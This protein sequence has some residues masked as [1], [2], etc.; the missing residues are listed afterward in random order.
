MRALA[1]VTF[2]GAAL[3]VASWGIAGLMQMP[4]WCSDGYHTNAGHLVTQIHSGGAAEAAG[5]QVGDRI[6]SIGGVP[7][8]DLP[9]RPRR[10]LPSVGESLAIEARR[11]GQ[12]LT[13]EL[14]CAAYPRNFRL[15]RING[16]IVS[17][18]FLA[19]AT[20]VLFVA[21][22][23]PGL[24]FALFGLAYGVSAFEG[25]RIGTLE[26]VAG[27]VEITA[28]LLWL[29][30][31][32]HLL[33]TF[34]KRKAIL[35]RRSTLWLLYAPAV[36]L[37]LFGVLDLLADPR[38]YVHF[39]VATAGLVAIYILLVITALVHSWVRSTGE[40]RK[41]SGF[42]L[43]LLALAIA[44][45]PQLARGF[46]AIAGLGEGLPGSAYY[47]LSAAVIPLAMATAIARRRGQ[48]V[49][50]QPEE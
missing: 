21:P 15:A 2:T 46:A 12:P 39:A 45:M 20:W 34:P 23:P 1:R 28:G 29:V 36:L 5:L 26:G 14:V 47:S 10:S 8:D 44:L 3:A 30:L 11:E 32:L 37:L 6:V 41:R 31:L 4:R 19:A 9:A 49:L 17:L 40:E 18:L 38:L 27:L 35:E 13:I 7:M 25:P 50:P 42:N 48:P 16:A 24:L 33:L 22:T 43:V